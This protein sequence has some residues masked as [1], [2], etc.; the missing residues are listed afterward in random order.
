M[1]PA[2]LTS[3]AVGDAT[4]ASLLTTMGLGLLAG[5]A[6]SVGPDHCAAMLTLTGAGG[7]GRRRR[8]FQVALRFALG[9]AVLLGGLAA[10]CLGLGVGLSEAFS[11]RAEIFGGAVLLAVALSALFLPASMRHGHPH[12]P[13]HE[14]DHRHVHL[15]GATGAL[16]AVSGVRGLLL[17]LPPLLVGGSLQAV[18]WAYVPAFALGIL[19]GRGVLGVLLAEGL[20]VLTAR[21][22]TWVERGAHVLAALV[23]L[24]WILMRL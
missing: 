8:A 10:V 2:S 5:L 9:H 24:S 15:S 21:L 6:H 11:T 17:A 13:G 19:I 22:G 23:G 16:L 12:L 18:A 7:E 3:S 4:A 20:G 14:T 1:D